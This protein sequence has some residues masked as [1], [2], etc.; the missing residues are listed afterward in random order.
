[1]QLFKKKNVLQK[2]RW[3]ERN[4]T[5]AS[6]ALSPISTQGQQH[7]SE[8]EESSIARRSFRHSPGVR[9]PLRSRHVL[10]IPARLGGL[11]RPAD[12]PAHDIQTPTRQVRQNRLND[13]KTDQIHTQHPKSTSNIQRA[14]IFANDSRCSLLARCTPPDRD[15][16]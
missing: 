9:L 11:L 13:R 16:R 7:R 3:G 14:A 2:K 1:M 5:T 15:T 4:A 10:C 6:R 8:G 12:S